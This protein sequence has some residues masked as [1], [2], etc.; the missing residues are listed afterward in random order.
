MHSRLIFLNNCKNGAYAR[1]WT[2][3]TKKG[4]EGKNGKADRLRIEGSGGWKVG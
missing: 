4:R 2:K 1:C 3:L